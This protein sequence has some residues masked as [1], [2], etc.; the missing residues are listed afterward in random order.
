MWQ[1]LLFTLTEDGNSSGIS[2]MLQIIRSAFHHD[3]KDIQIELLYGAVV[4]EDL[5]FR[6]TLDSIAALHSNFRPHYVINEVRI[7][8]LKFYIFSKR[9]YS[10]PVTGKVKWDS[11]QKTSC[12]SIC[13]LQ[14]MMCCLYFVDLSRCV[15]L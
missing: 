10:H 9:C 15:R 2:P 12:E 8:V 1:S 11:S 3:R 14:A 13:Q 5:V 7:F 4:E 6:T